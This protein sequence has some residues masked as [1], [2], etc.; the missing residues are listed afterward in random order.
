MHPDLLKDDNVA[1]EL[2]P[3]RIGEAKVKKTKTTVDDV[4]KDIQKLCRVIRDLDK[5]KDG[6]PMRSVLRRS[7]AMSQHF[8]S[9]YGML[10]QSS[11]LNQYRGDTRLLDAKLWAY[12]TEE[13]PGDR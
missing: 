13:R 8:T 11:P 7:T 3:R 9:R 6:F 10:K 5:N 2:G 4:P 1:K 12:L